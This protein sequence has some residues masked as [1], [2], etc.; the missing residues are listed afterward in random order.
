MPPAETE[1]A[2][3]RAPTCP[4]APVAPALSRRRARSASASSAARSAGRT[5]HRRGLYHSLR[6]CQL[7]PSPPP[8]MVTAGMP[9]DIA[10]LE[11]VD[12]PAKVTRG[13]RVTAGDRALGRLHDRRIHRDDAGG[14]VADQLDLDRQLVGFPARIFVRHRLLDEIEQA[15]LELE[16]FVGRVRAHV[17]RHPRLGGDGV[18]RGAAAHGAD[19]KGGLGIGRRL[20]IRDFG[21]RAAH[22]VDRARQSE[23]LE[24]VTAGPVKMN[25]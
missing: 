11:S 16:Q 24:G 5:R 7:P 25:S 12:E 14:A 9:S 2:R 18:D 1:L 4:A 15:R 8:P 13:P 21:D 23:L 6:E 22:G 19:G 17:D 10:I 3:S 20:Q